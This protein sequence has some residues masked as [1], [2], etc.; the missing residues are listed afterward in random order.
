MTGK[1]VLAKIH[2]T[3]LKNYKIRPIVIV[4]SYK[5][6]DFLYLPLTT[7][8]KIEGIL[9]QN[10]DLEKG[11]LKEDSIIVVPKIGILH[12]DFIERE[13]AILKK[14]TYDKILKAICHNFG[15]NKL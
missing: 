13:I 10:A 8:I 15:C 3:D 7:N 14:S 12:Y 1:I 6:E 4:K 9:I 11:Y 2:F 5:D